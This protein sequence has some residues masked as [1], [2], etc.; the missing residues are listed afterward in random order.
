MS[1][2]T[3]VQDVPLHKK[4]VFSGISGSIAT[5][6]IYPIDLVKTKLQDQKGGVRLY[7][8][9]VHC[10]K[11][12]FKNNGLRGLYQGWPPNVILVMPEKAL[13]LTLNDVFRAEIRKRREKHDLPFLWEMAAGGAAGFCQVIMTNPMEL[14]KIQGA[15]MAEKIKSG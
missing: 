9:P 5:T 10:F 2:S 1:S 4:V 15:T 14:L 6:C 11:T 12:I 3:A 8:S 7:E 13:K